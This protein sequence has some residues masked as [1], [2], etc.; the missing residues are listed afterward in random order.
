MQAEGLSEN[1]EGSCFPENGAR[2]RREAG[3][4]PSRVAG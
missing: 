3:A 2:A 4:D 1:S